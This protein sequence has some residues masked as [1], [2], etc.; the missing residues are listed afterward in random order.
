MSHQVSSMFAPS[1]GNKGFLLQVASGMLSAQPPLYA[2]CCG[3]R[4][5]LE[6]LLA[7]ISGEQPIII[8]LP[9]PM[10]DK[11]FY[12]ELV[13]VLPASHCYCLSAPQAD[14]S[15]CGSAST[16]DA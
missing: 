15:P 11:A 2:G 14:S 6:S 5:E 8:H 9:P 13:D 1:E 16:E 4:S 12:A 7:G 10:Q 3:L